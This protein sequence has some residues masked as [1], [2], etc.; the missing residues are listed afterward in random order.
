MQDL[1]ERELDEIMAMFQDGPAWH[2]ERLVT[3]IPYLV[4]ELR[5]R[6]G[7]NGPSYER[8]RRNTYPPRNSGNNNN[9]RYG[10][11]R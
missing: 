2:S 7:T 10:N 9:Q 3:A 5:R 6:R 8:D 4:N 11:R 1:T